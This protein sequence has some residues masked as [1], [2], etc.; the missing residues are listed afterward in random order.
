MWAHP[1]DAAVGIEVEHHGLGHPKGTEPGFA[2]QDSGVTGA[3]G[4]GPPQ[5]AD[6]SIDEGE[7]RGQILS[8][9]E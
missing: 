8:T 6:R 7:Q 2:Q 3:E 9:T 4:I 5:I 1:P